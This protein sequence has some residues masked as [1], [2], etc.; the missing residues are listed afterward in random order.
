MQTR[1]TSAL[2]LGKTFC[3]RLGTWEHEKLVRNSSKV[4]SHPLPVFQG[5]AGSR[6]H[7][8]TDGMWDF[9]LTH[10]KGLLQSI[11]VL[12]Y[13]MNGLFSNTSTYTYVAL[14]HGLL[15]WVSSWR[16]KLTLLA[17]LAF[18]FDISNKF[19][20][21]EKKCFFLNCRIC[22]LCLLLVVFKFIGIFPL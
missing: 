15:V 19:S 16:T 1:L 4:I 18:C 5:A 10:L 21:P 14:S 3:D 17:T 20:E 13:T 8:E 7:S 22:Q 12:G 2:R 6:C 9:L 11:K